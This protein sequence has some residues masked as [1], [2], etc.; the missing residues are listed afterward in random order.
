MSVSNKEFEQW[1][2]KE[3]C[4]ADLSQP[5]TRK[6]YN[7]LKYGWQAAKQSM[8]G[9]AVATIIA[10]PMFLPALKCPLID[11]HIEIMS[12]PLGT[13]LY[14]HAPD[15]AATIAELQAENEALRA[16][17]SNIIDATIS[18]GASND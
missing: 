15:S 9:E 17:I 2:D 1:F 18:K 14:T 11:W 8:Q 4:D 16:K 7:N 5:E 10:D 6:G 13:K 3:F 12:L